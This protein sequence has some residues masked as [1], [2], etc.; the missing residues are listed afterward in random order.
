MTRV[1]ANGLSNE[2]WLLDVEEV[3]GFERIMFRRL[4]NS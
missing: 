4:E 3:N 1:Y 2:K